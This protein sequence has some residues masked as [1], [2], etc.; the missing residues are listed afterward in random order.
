MYFGAS[1]TNLASDAEK[2]RLERPPPDVPS[3]DHAGLDSMNGTRGPMNYLN[4]L[5]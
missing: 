3:H 2:G 5:F 4:L 1:A